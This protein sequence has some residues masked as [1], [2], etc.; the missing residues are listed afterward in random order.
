MNQIYMYRYTLYMHAITGILLYF[1]L[2]YKHL[3]YDKIL[4]AVG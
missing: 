3:E 1:E 2:F 4:S